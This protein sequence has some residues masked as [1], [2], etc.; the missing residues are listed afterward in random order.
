MTLRP[1]PD[2]EIV[3]LVRAIKHRIEGLAQITSTPK[4]GIDVF[5][6]NKTPFLQLE[7]RRDHMTLDLW[8]PSDRLEEARA[9]G[10]ARA[11]PFL[12]DDAV[13]VRFERAED[14]SRVARWLEA[15]YA[16]APDRGRTRKKSSKPVEKSIPLIK[17]PPASGSRPSHPAASSAGS[18][19]PAA[20]AS[21]PGPASGASTAPASA[22]PRSRGT[23]KTGGGGADRAAAKRGAGRAGAKKAAGR[24]GKKAAAAKSTRAKTAA[25]SARARP[26][27][28]AGKGARPTKTTAKGARA[29]K[30]AAKGGQGR[31][32]GGR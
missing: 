15:S 16:Y 23:K 29:G 8:L 32:A 3:P 4:D 18:A 30:V 31:K 24:K 21:A 11:H 13:K 28:S 14:L 6:R 9:S 10:I 25:K 2:P 5:F 1:T 26:G 22:G 17:P 27:K 20:G 19:A 7:I 12:G